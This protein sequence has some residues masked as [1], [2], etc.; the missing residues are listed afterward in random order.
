MSTTAIP[1]APAVNVPPI[2][3]PKFSVGGEFFEGRF[4]F[5]SGFFLESRCNIAFVKLS[6]WI[7]LQLRFGRI[8][9]VIFTLTGAMLGHLQPVPGDPSKTKWVPTPMAAMDLATAVTTEEVSV[10]VKIYQ[11]VMEKVAAEVKRSAEALA[12]PPPQSLPVN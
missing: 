4:T 3:F 1:T 8:T 12:T 6:E 7:D 9:T 5:A 11:Q 2:E 10:I